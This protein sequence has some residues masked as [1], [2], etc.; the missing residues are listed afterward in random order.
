[1]I[2]STS[3]W[4][5]FAVFDQ[6]FCDFLTLDSNEDDIV[7]PTSARQAKLLRQ[8]SQNEINGSIE[9]SVAGSVVGSESTED[10]VVVLSLNRTIPST[11]PPVS[12]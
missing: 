11:V 9:S 1:M 8:E 7:I 3:Q 12:G 5:Y 2:V 10:D 6:P 4:R